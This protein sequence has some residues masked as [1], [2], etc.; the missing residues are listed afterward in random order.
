MYHAPRLIS[1]AKY[2]AKFMQTIRKSVGNVKAPTNVG[3]LTW[4][5]WRYKPHY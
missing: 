2:T 3:A 4:G 1:T 5:W